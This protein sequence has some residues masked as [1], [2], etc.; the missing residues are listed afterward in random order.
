MS[1]GLSGVR[2]EGELCAEHSLALQTSALADEQ[3]VVVALK[4]RYEKIVK[5]REINHTNVTD[6]YMYMQIMQVYNK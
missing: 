5:K 1:E 4:E 3:V 2:S 6:K